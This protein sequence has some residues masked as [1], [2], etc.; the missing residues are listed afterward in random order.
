MTMMIAYVHDGRGTDARNY[1]VTPA[2]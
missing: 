2:A 1:R